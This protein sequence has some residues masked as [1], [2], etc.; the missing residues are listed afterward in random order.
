[1][2]WLHP[3]RTDGAMYAH[4]R[5]HGTAFVLFL[6]GLSLACGATPDATGPDPIPPPPDSRIPV[7][8]LRIRMAVDGGIAGVGYAFEVDGGSGEIRGLHC[9]AHCPWQAGEVIAVVSSRQVESLA[10]MLLDGGLLTLDRSD[11]G[12]ECCDQTNIVLR[13]SDGI[14]DKTVRGSTGTLPRGLL[15][16]L[17]ALHALAHGIRPVLVDLLGSVEDWPR[18]PAALRSVSLDGSLLRL[19]VEYSGGCRE[20]LFDLVA[21]NGWLESYP[22]QVGV[23]LAHDDRGDACEALVTRQLTFDLGPLRRAYEQ[24]YGRGSETIVMRLIEP[25]SPDPQDVRFISYTF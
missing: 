10:R 22:V 9:D 24:A 6:A 20:H 7:E 21:W 14:V 17:S 13:Y 2:G 4:V 5:W 12:T 25:S 16:G 18:D 23:L 1:M 15:P 19:E 11:F 3:Q 8:D